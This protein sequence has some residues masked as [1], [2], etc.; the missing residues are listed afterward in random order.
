M[1]NIGYLLEGT[2]KMHVVEK[3]VRAGAWMHRDFALS[4]PASCGLPGGGPHPLGILPRVG[5]QP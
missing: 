2:L 1:S 4:G 5:Q 3:N